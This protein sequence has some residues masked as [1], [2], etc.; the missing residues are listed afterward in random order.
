VPIRRLELELEADI[1]TTDVW[2]TSDIDPKP[3]GFGAVLVS[4]QLD[5][6]ASPETRQGSLFAA[7]DGLTT[8]SQQPCIGN[9]LSQAL[10][11]EVDISRVSPHFDVRIAAVIGRQGVA[12]G[13]LDLSGQRLGRSR[14]RGTVYD[15]GEAILGEGWATAAPMPRDAA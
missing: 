6:D 7:A 2:G 9:L 1:N 5:A 15:D 11:A 3:I 4:V 14:A 13:R 12:T 8:L 10:P